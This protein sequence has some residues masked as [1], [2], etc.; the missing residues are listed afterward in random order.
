MRK[1][2]VFKSVLLLV[3][4]NGAAIATAQAGNLA[5]EISRIGNS[6]VE[7]G[8]QL[9][10]AVDEQGGAPFTVGSGL[11]APTSVSD[12]YFADNAKEQF[13]RLIESASRVGASVNSS[14]CDGL[15]AELASGKFAA[16]LD[17]QS[18]VLVGGSEA[19]A[20]QANAVS[21]PAAAWLFSSA[22]FGFVVVANRRKV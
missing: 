6:C 13:N 18:K 20:N 4:F 7:S 14:A 10:M 16:N 1:S 5:Y 3:L 9:G 8:L 19:F 22:L 15:M 17:V 2:V 11:G 21:L 12:I